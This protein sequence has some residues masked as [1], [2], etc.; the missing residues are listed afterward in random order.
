VFFDSPVYFVFL[1]VVVLIYWQ[2]NQ[3]RQNVF[4][5]AASYLFYGWWDWRFLTLIIISTIV[6][7][8]LSH[9][10]ERSNDDTRRFRIM[11]ASIVLNV[12]F[13]AYF[14][15]ANFFVDSMATLLAGMGFQSVN[16]TFLE[17]VLPPGISFY[18]FQAI[19]YIVDVHDRRIKPAKTVIDYG[20]FVSLFPHLVAGPI[21]RPDHLLPQVERERKLDPER[22]RHGLM[23]IAWGLFRKCVIA[24]NC[25]LV[26]DAVYSGKL[27]P[28]SLPLV[29]LG[30]YAFAWQIY[31]DFSG[32]SQIARGSAHLMGFDFMINFRQPFL[33]TTVQDLWQRWHISLGNWLRDY[34]FLRL[35]GSRKNGFL[36]NRNQMITMLVCGLWHGAN[37]TYVIWGALHGLALV[38]G[39]MSFMRLDARGRAKEKAELST[40]KGFTRLWLKRAAVFHIFALSAVFFRS[41]SVEY[42]L[43]L[44]GSVTSLQVVAGFGTACL[45]VAMFA[46]VLLAV[47]LINE[48]DQSEYPF[49][50]ATFPKMVASAAVALLLVAVMTGNNANG[51]IYFQF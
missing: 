34:V 48:R 37:W 26:A 38:I 27:G 45:L 20:L 6:D 44:L 36:A 14:K 46:A 11:V 2:L 42:S 5:L 49:E 33:A 21:Q 18:T 8:Y 13:L 35:R 3:Q 41:P 4:L 43:K 47:D 24:D 39:R 29:L 50:K 19:A 30:A 28:P 31:A 40:L 7:F 32:Y 16:R 22:V 17:V 51:F 10:I 12:G 9:V 25:A 1:T 15:Y 23:L